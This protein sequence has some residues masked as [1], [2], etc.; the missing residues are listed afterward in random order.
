MKAR[1]EI[2]PTCR[3]DTRARTRARARECEPRIQE[4]ST[5]EGSSDKSLIRTFARETGY[6]LI[7]RC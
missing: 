1:K 2:N 6:T 5:N 3:D 4:I 7:F